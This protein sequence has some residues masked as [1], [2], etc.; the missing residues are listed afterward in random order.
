MAVQPS[1]LLKLCCHVKWSLMKAE[2]RPS[3]ADTATNICVNE[4]LARYSVSVYIYLYVITHQYAV[5]LSMASVIFTEIGRFKWVTE[6]KWI[7]YK[8][9]VSRSKNTHCGIWANIV[10]SGSLSPQLTEGCAGRLLK[11]PATLCAK[12]WTDAQYRTLGK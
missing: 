2:T 5:R 3:K 9:G 4:K 6:K 11:T 1:V 12:T 7:N 10:L 8:M